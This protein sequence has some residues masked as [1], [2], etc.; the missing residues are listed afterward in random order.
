MRRSDIVMDDE[1]LERFFDQ[2]SLINQRGVARLGV[3]CYMAVEPGSCST[4]ETRPAQDTI[5]IRLSTAEPETNREAPGQIPPLPALA[6]SEKDAKRGGTAR[7]LARLAA[8]LRSAPASRIDS[9]PSLAP[10]VEWSGPC[11]AFKKS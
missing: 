1:R 8:S 6:S 11:T 10:I 2:L 7:L 9:L 3:R 5:P 4:V